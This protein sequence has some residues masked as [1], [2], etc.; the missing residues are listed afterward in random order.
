MR[1]LVQRSRFVPSEIVFSDD[2][3]DLPP[4]GTAESIQ[5]TQQLVKEI[6]KADSEK[7]LSVGF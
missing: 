3:F 5:Q 7:L 2:D 6:C 1:N 4:T